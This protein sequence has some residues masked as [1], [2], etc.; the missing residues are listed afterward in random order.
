MAGVREEKP[1]TAPLIPHVLTERERLFWFVVFA[2]ASIPVN[3]A[4][5]KVL[6]NLF[7]PG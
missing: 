7:G 1:M 2:V 5:I 4:A 3:V 6:D